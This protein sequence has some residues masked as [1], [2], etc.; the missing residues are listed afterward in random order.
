MIFKNQRLAYLD[1]S[2]NNI[3]PSGAKIIAKILK[4]E[5]T[6]LRYLDLSGNDFQHDSNSINQLSQGLK[7]QRDLFHL[8]IDASSIKSMNKVY[9][10]S[11]YITALLT[12]NFILNI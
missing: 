6:H 11:E 9:K 8:C 5:A 12:V 3:G 2:K 4:E 1:L 10:A 7:M